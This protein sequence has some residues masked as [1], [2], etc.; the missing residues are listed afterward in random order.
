[1]DRRRIKRQFTAFV[2]G[3][4]ILFV[5]LCILSFDRGDPPSPSVLPVN[6][7][8]Q[9]W[10]GPVGATVAHVAL[11]TLGAGIYVLLL[12][13]VL[14]TVA[15]FRDRPF[16][17][18]ILR[19]IG[20]VLVL[21]AT[22][23]LAARAVPGALSPLPVGSGGYLGMAVTCFL[24]TH[25][26]A[27][28]SYL[29]LLASL[30]VGLLLSADRALVRIGSGAV[31]G[32]RDLLR[33]VMPPRPAVLSVGG[34]T[35][36][37]EV[38]P[39]PVAKPVETD[40]EPLPQDEEEGEPD[41][42]L[43]DTGLPDTGLPDTGLPDTELVV[44][45]PIQVPQ[46]GELEADPPA[47]LP[48]EPEPVPTVDLPVETAMDEDAPLGDESVQPEVRPDYK[49][50][51]IELLD[52]PE[53]FAF[54]EHERIVR[55]KAAI[56]EQTFRDFG[57]SV[58][59]VAIDTGPV[60][61]QFEVA[62]EAGLRVN[63]VL[64]LD[65]DLAIALKAH[66]VRIV[67]PL[68]GKNTVG[69]EVPNP[70]RA[71]VRMKEVIGGIGERAR[72]YRLPVYL[73]KD[74]SGS[75]LAYDLTEL[76]H[77]LI[78]GRTGSGKSVCINSI[79]VSLMLTQ[80]PD[81][82]R[83][84]LVDPKMV[85]LAAFKRIPHLMAPLV[86]DM[87]K[88]EAVLAWAV[89]KMDERYDLLA[90][91]GVRS[92]VGYN[93][94]GAEEIYRRFDPQSDEERVRIPEHMPYI[95]IIIDELADLMMT[96]GKEVELYV[97]RLAQK[98]R[99]VG[100]HLILATQRP[101][102]DVITGLIKS[103]LPARLSFQVA[104]R[105]DSRTILDEIGAEKLLGNGDMLFTT[106]AGSPIRAQGAFVSDEE[107]KAIVSS[108]ATEEPTYSRELVQ[109]RSAGAP[110]GKKPGGSKRD[111]L[112]EHA[113]KVVIMNQR[114]S[115]SLLQRA[116]EIGYSRA[117]RLVDMMA[118]DGIVGEYQGSQAR[119]VLFSPEDWEALE[120]ETRQQDE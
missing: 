116:L 20:V 5:T 26:S 110:G 42:G 25:F 27:V 63:R 68:P 99:A 102:V 7:P 62:L 114:G 18:L 73:A 105:V 41:T 61:T 50:P 113:V 72:K 53:P 87:K 70:Q 33:P 111:E 9:N 58:R 3:F 85:E 92:I 51:S 47:A 95:V 10:C 117:A 91:A 90:R 57:L 23:A 71:V 81:E 66:S 46:V 86:T 54:H 28:G 89:D 39:A 109:L 78:A 75:P 103:N 97:T 2:L 43:P 1:L 80:R 49:L 60:I 4:V 15:A 101:S 93:R 98:S 65:R 82:V 44:R 115:V 77:L 37:A 8:V 74:A 119:E 106:G 112:Y 19:S 118:E 16:D 100:L 83:L 45:A 104:S 32:V 12:V 22:S 120:K 55:E 79:I 30:G 13:G 17:D 107:I 69:I 76:P 40:P 6:D 52:N 35:A 56:L 29:M 108:V 48:V 67:A 14:L 36:V 94:L 59:V 38:A 21:G 24:E 84:L 11:S 64:N 31:Q 34:A 88:A 96:S